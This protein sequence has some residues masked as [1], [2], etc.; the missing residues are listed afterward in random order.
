M[1]ECLF[2]D[3]LRI[4][5]NHDTYSSIDVMQYDTAREI[6]ITIDKYEIPSGTDARIY[7][8]KPSGQEIYDACTIDNNM[9]IVHPTLQML[10]ETGDN[11]ATIQLTKNAS[12]L[13]S[14]VF[15]IKVYKNITS[16][17]AIESSSEYT[18]LDG[19]ITDARNTISALNDKINE[20]N[21]LEE[22]IEDAVA[23]AINTLET[24]VVA[25]TTEEIDSLFS[26]NS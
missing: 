2:K 3:Y 8:K 22:S 21:L 1:E 17:S 7:V 15:N 5:L 25:I 20:V 13:T 26:Q 23:E 4:F 6:N 10:A 24:K 19:L 9:V 16:D 12:V 18:I 14:F 11:I